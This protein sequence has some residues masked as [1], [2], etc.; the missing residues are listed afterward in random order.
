MLSIRLSRVGKKNQ[1]LFR[2][3]VIDE[4]KDPWGKAVEILG[5]RNP[6]SKEMVLNV[7][8]VKYWLSKGAQPSNTV[9]NILI[10][11]KILEGQ[12]KHSVTHISKKRRTKMDEKKAKEAPKETPAAEAPKSETPAA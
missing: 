1:P 10:D 6:R 9:A 7:E 5:N 3:I 2:L 4:H 8:R 11:Q 12:K